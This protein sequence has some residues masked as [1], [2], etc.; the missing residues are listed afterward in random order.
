MS[1]QKKLLLFIILL[2]VVSLV[3]SLYPLPSLAQG[4]RTDNVVWRAGMGIGGVNVAVC[5]PLATTGAS[6]TA[7]LATFTMSSNPQTAGFVSGMTIW[8]AGFTGADTYLNAGTL[9]AGFQI[10]GG[11]TVLS[12]TPTQIIALLTHANAVASTNGTVLQMGNSTTSCGGLSV[13]YTDSTLST[14]SGI[15]PVVSDGYGNYG[16][17]V[18]PGQYYTQYYGPTVTTTIRPVTVTGPVTGGSV[19]LA[20]TFFPSSSPNCTLSTY[21]PTGTTYCAV[22]A[23]TGAITSGTDAG[24]VINTVINARAAT[25][26]LFFFRNGVYNINSLTEDTYSS[27]TNY[28]YGIGIPTASYNAANLVQFIFEGES[29]TEWLGESGSGN[30]ETNGVIFNVTPAAVTTAPLGTNFIAGVFQRSNSAGGCGN[31]AANIAGHGD[32]FKN[33]TVRFPNNQRGNEGAFVM[34]YAGSVDY[35]NTMADFNVPYTTLAATGP[36]AGASGLYGMT[37]TISGSGNTE[38]FLNTY[39]VGYDVGYDFKSEHVVSD[40]STA[41][42]CNYPAQIGAGGG[43]LYHPIVLTKFTDQENLNGILLGV[44]IQKGTQISIIGLDMELGSAGKWYTRN[45]GGMIED[46]PGN[47]S[48]II[49]Y[50][51]VRAGTG[52]IEVPNSALFVKGGGGFLKEEGNQNFNSILPIPSSITWATLYNNTSDWG[53]GWLIN[54][55]SSGEVVAGAA[56]INGAFVGQF[57]HQ[58]SQYSLPDQFS[59]VTVGSV[60]TSAV[61]G[62][63]VRAAP[64]TATANWYSYSGST[65]GTGLYPKRVINKVTAGVSSTLATTA[66]NTGVGPGDVLELDVIG[67]NLYA[68]YNGVLDLTT[69]DSTFTSGFPGMEIVNGAG[70]ATATAW[71]GGSFPSKNGISSIFNAPNFWLQTQTFNS[72]ILLPPVAFAGLPGCASAFEG[73]ERAIADS[74]TA[75]WGATITGSG[76]NHVLGYCDGTNWTVVGK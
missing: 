42:Y 24:V 22:D 72:G 70:A 5:Q 11:L 31:L 71:S 14:P 36:V 21:S 67:S 3:V 40:T 25:G 19:S 45:N 48:G 34:W 20:S 39:A 29:R 7:N 16:F 51:A 57:A 73:T 43:A 50:V 49:T 8:V 12:V 56:T 74:T 38:H 30:I 63:I 46:N 64:G 35:N 62:A 17:W 75:V 66:G 26:G 2:F 65:S 23:N 69:T 9:S 55:G 37:S 52:I 6:V 27:C 53:G 76:A 58:E 4:G 18:T 10:T 33:I 41:I 44:N 59:I 13:L 32:Y 47:S 54:Q 61:V 68:Y 28:Y 60:T 1:S 15:N